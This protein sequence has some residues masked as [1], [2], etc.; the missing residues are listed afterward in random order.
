MSTNERYAAVL[1]AVVDSQDSDGAEGNSDR[2]VA[3]LITENVEMEIEM[4]VMR[5]T[6][7]SWQI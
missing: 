5:T 4:V 6:V 2:G 1:A 3:M 7:V